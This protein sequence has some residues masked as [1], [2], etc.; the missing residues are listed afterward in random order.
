MNSKKML[1]AFLC[2]T[3]LI[4]MFSNALYVIAE[5][6]NAENTITIGTIAEPGENKTGVN[7]REDAGTNQNRIYT[8]ADGSMVTVNGSKNDI[9]NTINSATNKPYVWYAVSFKIENTNYNGY[10][11]EDLIKVTTYKLDKS[12]E[13]QLTDF[14][15]SYRN[16]LTA[17]HAIYP[18]WKFQAD[19]IDLT[20][21]EAISLESVYPR[22]VVMD[23]NAISWSSMNDGWYNWN[24]STFV[25]ADANFKGASREVIAYYMDP[26]NFL[27][28]NDVYIFLKQSYDTSQ[29]IEGVK[30][31][32]DG[33]N[34]FK[35]YNDP[36]DTAFGGD[37]AAV[38]MEAAKQSGVSPYI[39]ASTM[40]L[41]QGSNG[42][43]L[44]NGYNYNGTVVYNFFNIGA[45]G[46]G[47]EIYVNG[48]KYA[49]NQGW[50][51]RSKAIIEGA[52]FYANNYLNR[53][54]SYTPANAYYNQ[55]TYFYKN[56]NILDK[57]NI[58]HQYAQNIQDSV[59][60]ASF[61]R[62]LYTN[63]FT[64]AL[65]FRIPVYKDNSLPQEA[66]TLPE[67]TD[68]L[69]NYFLND[70]QAYGLTPSFERYTYSYT[71]QAL[72]DT[73]VYVELPQKATLESKTSFDLTAG[74]NKIIITVKSET[75]FTNDYLISVNATNNSK[76]TITTNAQDIPTKP[77][78]LKGDANNDG[79]I[80]ISD[81]ATVRLHL[82]NITPLTDKMLIGADA[83]GD[84]KVSISDLA[85]LRLHLLGIT[86][87]QN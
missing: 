33:K 37:F 48:A 16:A 66:T 36:N 72:G 10:V 57:K 71:L 40:A 44:G 29:N 78:V 18:N 38:I 62:G 55:D 58:D 68:K 2:I 6:I 3:L 60:S 83:N 54:N 11:R 39:L 65:T 84:G 87:I 42:N 73:T 17:L 52:K 12:F 34:L 82:L 1:S 64:T 26:R 63:D 74:E 28:A 81:L 15:E 5:E 59:S 69:N 9:N 24:N 75:G 70:I 49:Y 80:S 13:E 22:K 47:N 21:S 45:S 67:K 85:T 76:L 79:K 19:K 50:T 14:P 4:S 23:R 27:N 51:T 77:N 8:L 31:I 53:G 25:T 56:F 41:E 7:V 86:L 61:L 32:I 20:F 35:N 30:K 43:P 46:N